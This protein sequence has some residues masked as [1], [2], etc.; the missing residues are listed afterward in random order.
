MCTSAADMLIL[1]H[2]CI[3]SHFHPL[4]IR[5]E[6]TSI[7]PMQGVP[8]QLCKPFNKNNHGFC[9]H[10]NQ[11]NPN[12]PI[13]CKQLFKCDSRMEWEVTVTSL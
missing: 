10:K 3:Y 2:S 1:V 7:W 11:S 13:S 8:L 9:R 4:P 5:L 12:K 6:V